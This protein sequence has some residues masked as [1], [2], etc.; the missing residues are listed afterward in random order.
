MSVNKEYLDENEL[1]THIGV[2]LSTIR[3]WRVEG[4]G[5]LFS[6]MEGLVR[7]KVSDVDAFAEETKV[8]DRK[9]CGN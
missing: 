7:Y 8:R 4:R 1:S 6:K 9:R 5:P 3:K 2:K